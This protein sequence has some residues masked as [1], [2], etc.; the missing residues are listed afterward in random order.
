MIVP[1]KK[2]TLIGRKEEREA[3]LK[4]LQ[5][6]GCWMVIGHAG[7]ETTSSAAKAVD[8]RETQEA[9]RFLKLHRD[10]KRRR[11]NMANEVSYEEYFG[12][13]EDAERVV[14]RAGVIEQEINTLYS[15]IDTLNRQKEQMTIGSWEPDED[16]SEELRSVE[17]VEDSVRILEEEIAARKEETEALSVH[18]GE[19]ELLY[20]RQKSE[21]DLLAVRSQDTKTCFRVQGWIR[22]DRVEVVENA[23]SGV[24]DQ[25]V[26]EFADP[27]EGEIPP[28]ETQNNRITRPFTEVTNLYSRP[29]PFGM[30][31]NALVAPFYT[32]FF[33]MMMA[34]AGYGILMTIL[35]LLVQK[36][37]K[38][39][40]SL[41]RMVG[42]VL[43]GSISTIIWGIL[44]G[45]WF[46]FELT[47]LL[48]SPLNEPILLL[49]LC[50][51]FGLLH[52][53]TGRCARMYLLFK[54]K[55][56]LDIVFDQ[57][58][59]ISLIAGLILWAISAMAAMP[60]LAFGKWMALVGALVILV[61]GGR[62]KPSAVGKV[63]GGLASLY[64]ITGVLGDILSYSRILALALSASVI[65]LVVNT[66][67][68]LLLGIP[69]AG[70]L[71][72]AVIFLGGHAFN[73][74][75]STLS[76]YIHSS[77]LQFIEF[78]GQFYE[79]GGRAFQPLALSE[80]YV[81]IYNLPGEEVRLAKT[82]EKI[83]S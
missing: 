14:A 4:T 13:V 44:F 49:G 28:S 38:P 33:G 41:G 70:I 26:L 43:F 63:T 47:P 56:Y 54:R 16:D 29:S 23:L 65:G 58:S 67:C 8:M 27:A 52:L 11:K 32:L 59:W 22:H 68:Q 51:G 18:R 45:G 69:V 34:D 79:A 2:G 72:A 64:N 6:T 77:R 75:L 25:Y 73:I 60:A 39:R 24:T 17:E 82:S 53:L 40:G 80:R 5:A 66:I 78:F 1:M 9:I 36:I 20:D 74:A 76:S 35:L 61:T 57:L 30:D 42:V 31:P 55:Q 12:S 37:M 46:G 7:E 15:R 19:L 62:K 10:K 81:R 83:R 50:Y 3:L 48:F 21:H 71:I